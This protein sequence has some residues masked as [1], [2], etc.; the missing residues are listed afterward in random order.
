MP[1]GFPYR[2]MAPASY[3]ALEREKTAKEKF[4]IVKN[5]FEERI[6]PSIPNVPGFS[7]TME[8]LGPQTHLT[9]VTWSTFNNWVKEHPGWKAKR[10]VAS[11]EEKKAACAYNRGKSYFVNAVYTVPDPNKKKQAQKEERR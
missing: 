10:R 11:E 1:P 2:C 6:L 7:H 5:D 9:S 8:F 3:A 4:L